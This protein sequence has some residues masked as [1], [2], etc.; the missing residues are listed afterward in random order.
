MT[1]R[2]DISVDEVRV[3]SGIDSSL[4]NDADLLDL[5]EQAEYASERDIN[6]KC[7]PSTIVEFPKGDNSER[8]VLNKNPVLK[9]RG[10][11]VDTTSID[12]DDIRVDFDSGVV[13]LE[14]TADKTMFVK[15]SGYKNL[16]KVKYDYGLLEATNSQ[17]SSTSDVSAGDSV[18][19]S[20]DDSS[21][22]SSGDYVRIMG[23]DG[24]EEVF[25]VDSVSDST[26]IVADK[27][28]TSH[29]SGSLLTLLQVPSLFKTLVKV[30]ASLY[31]AANIIGSSYDIIVSYGLGDMSVNKGVPYPH[32]NTSIAKFAQARRELLKGFRQRP[33]VK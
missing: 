28:V 22:F 2:Y 4:I 16:V 11:E 15:K 27:L 7:I 20:V 23:F 5:I 17:A 29:E 26:T 1:S 30:N 9:I 21:D 24:L 31:G 25:E 18:S 19:I 6:C 33:V 12:L 14:A 32:W 13:W 8:I 10:L 3:Y